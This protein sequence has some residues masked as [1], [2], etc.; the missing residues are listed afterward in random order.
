M[1]IIRDRE[2]RMTQPRFLNDPH[3]LS[4]EINP[5]SLQRHFFDHL[6]EVE[7]C[8]PERAADIA[9]RNIQ[10][11]VIDHVAH[12]TAARE[13]VG[14]LSLCDAPDN[15]L[16]WAHYANEH[17]GA[18]LEID[19]GELALPEVGPG[20]VQC[21]AE[22]IYSDKR[23]DY[24]V[25]R[26]ALWMTLVYKSRAWAYEREWRLLKSLSTLRRK[27]EDVFVLEL[28]AKA[29]RSVV[30]GA[31][32]LGPDE[33]AVFAL[34][35]KPEYEH[36]TIYKAAF[37]SELVGLN[38][39]TGE[40]FAWSILHGEHHFG[41]NWRQLRQWVNM[42]AFEKAERGVGLPASATTSRDAG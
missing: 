37:S 23:V 10:G 11:M 13:E 9:C 2:I 41:D 19:V 25:E 5:Q 39:L 18:A 3:E 7:G 30:F 12:V 14:I 8:T 28:P 27:T 1:N 35:K 6:V 20:N 29:I 34:L 38:L 26:I 40:Q 31:R 33:E 21:L 32:A 42:E 22:V 17:C 16:L 24:I 36:V 4:V 15:M